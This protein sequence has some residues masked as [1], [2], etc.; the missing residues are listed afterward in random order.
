M[1]FREQSAE[2]GIWTQDVGWNSKL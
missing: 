2:K 1:V